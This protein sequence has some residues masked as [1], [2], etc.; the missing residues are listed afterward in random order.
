[1]YITQTIVNSKFFVQVTAHTDV[2]AVDP[3][4]SSDSFGLTRDRVVLG[5]HH[6]AKEMLWTVTKANIN[7]RLLS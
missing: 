7:H 5:P 6:C 4:I 3:I 2:S 1:M